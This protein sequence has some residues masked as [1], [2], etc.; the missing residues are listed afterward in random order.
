[1]PADLQH[2]SWVF[3]CDTC[4]KTIDGESDDF[5][6]AWAHAKQDGWRAKKIG[7]EWV[8]GCPGCGV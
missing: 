4:D 7:D 6:K 3:E 1:M 5:A 2:G 8:R